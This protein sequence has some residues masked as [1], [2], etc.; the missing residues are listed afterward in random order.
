MLLGTFSLFLYILAVRSSVVE[1]AVYVGHDGAVSM[2][3]KKVMRH[4]KY[5]QTESREEVSQPGVGRNEITDVVEKDAA[6]S[7][8]KHSAMNNSKARA[9]AVELDV[10]A[11]AQAELEGEHAMIPGLNPADIAYKAMDYLYGTTSSTEGDYPFAC[12]CNAE[13][14]CDYDMM[15]TPCSSRKLLGNGALRT[16]GHLSYGL[17][18]TFFV[19]LGRIHS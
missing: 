5:P 18:L 3:N 12:K 15:K 13:G 1:Q 16:Q 9:A 2:S 11:Q 14:V 10:Q 17:L 7:T 4:D 8:Q 19:M 6:E